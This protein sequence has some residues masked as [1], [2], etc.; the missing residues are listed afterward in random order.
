M[1][2]LS[3]DTPLSTYSS[4]SVIK[5]AAGS[6]DLR[7]QR[8]SGLATITE[9]NDSAG[10]PT[11]LSQPHTHAHA[12][13]TRTPV[14]LRQRIVVTATAGSAVGASALPKAQQLG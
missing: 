14:Y 10:A 13:K 12:V 1:H 8:L 5:S 9:H 4:F 3:R 7:C 11:E 6:G 2:T